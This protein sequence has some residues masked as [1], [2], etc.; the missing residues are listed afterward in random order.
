MTQ[1]DK[2][3]VGITEKKKK[4][5][6]DLGNQVINA[7]YEVDQLQAT[8][9][10]VTDKSQKI[11]ACLAMSE[12]DKTH[13]LN[14]KNILEEVVKNVLTLRNNSKMVFDKIGSTNAA[15][16]QLAKDAKVL[17]DKLIFSAEMINKLSMLIIRKKALN[18]LISDE[19][20]SFVNTAGKDA[21]N[22]VAL[23]LVALKSTFAA[24]ASSINSEAA[25]ALEYTQAILLYQVLTGTI[26][27]YNKADENTSDNLTANLDSNNNATKTC[28]RVLLDN[29]YL[30][31]KTQHE[32]LYTASGEITKQLNAANAKSNKA[33]IKLKSLQ[34]GL[35]AATAAALAF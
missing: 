26:E 21:N 24:Q 23:T 27:V 2:E 1:Q 30:N 3:K 10:A 7:Q 14:N 13:T 22:A 4:E 31:A 19:L 8:V 9:I 5:L 29:A 35:A 12:V 6:D 16:K 20:V 11:I 34:S 33:H 32:L 15:T 17:V 18:P 25:G 28:L